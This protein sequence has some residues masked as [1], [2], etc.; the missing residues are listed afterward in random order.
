MNICMQ[1]F[2]YKHFPIQTLHLQTFV[3]L[4]FSTHDWQEVGPYLLSVLSPEPII[5]VRRAV[6]HSKTLQNDGLVNIA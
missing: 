5:V 3:R 2:D 1:T 6:R 4:P